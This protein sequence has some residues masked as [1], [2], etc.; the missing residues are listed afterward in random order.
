LTAPDRA[1]VA[2]VRD[3][4]AGHW[5]GQPA[6]EVA[7]MRRLTGSLAHGLWALDGGRRLRPLGSDRLGLFGE[8]VAEFHIGDPTE[9][10]DSWRPWRRRAKLIEE[11][12]AFRLGRG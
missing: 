12:R 2:A 9:V 10:G 4:L 6:E 7:E 3:G 11:A 5:I 8:F 1:A